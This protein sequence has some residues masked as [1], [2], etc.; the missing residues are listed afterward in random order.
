MRLFVIRL[1]YKD[2][3]RALIIFPETES[4]SLT[5]E[6]ISQSNTYIARYKI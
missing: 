1:T 3:D 4:E 2:N 6:P 5:I